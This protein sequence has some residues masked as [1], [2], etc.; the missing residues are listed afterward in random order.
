MNLRMYRLFH[1]FFV[2]CNCTIVQS[3]IDLSW[4]L[5]IGF[6]FLCNV[7]HMAEGSLP[8]LSCGN[9]FFVWSCLALVLLL[10]RCCLRGETQIWLGILRVVLSVF[11]VMVLLI[12]LPLCVTVQHGSSSLTAY[13]L[14][15]PF[16]W[17]ALTH[18]PSL[19]IAGVALTAL[20]G[21]WWRRFP[22]APLR[23][24][25]QAWHLATSVFPFAWQAWH[26]LTSTFTFHSKRGTSGRAGS[27]GAAGS[28]G[29]AAS[30]VADVTL[31]D[32]H[33]RFAWPA[34]HPLTSTFTLRSR[35]GTYGDIHL[36]FA[37]EAFAVPHVGYVG[38]M[39]SNFWVVW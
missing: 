36:R 28:R 7:F 2:K 14:A 26:S 19:C 6:H 12:L 15:G 22:S 18:P 5:L 16:A 24:T 34:W 25:Q 27:G 8:S 1:L 32:T 23:L 17:Q 37:W 4:N 21:L 10:L 39:L 30:D 3:L 11:R 13:K 33:L 38:C 31:G 35:R 9:W 20:G 29:R